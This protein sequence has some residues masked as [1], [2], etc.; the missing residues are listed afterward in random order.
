MCSAFKTTCVLM[1]GICLAGPV[2]ARD[3]DHA[4][5]GGFDLGLVPIPG[6]SFQMMKHAVTFEQWDAC[7]NDGG[8]DHYKPKDLAGRGKKPVININYDDAVY[9]AQWASS[10]TGKSLR[11]PTEAE[12]EYAARGGVHT[13][14]AFG[15]QVDCTQASYGH[16]P[17]GECSASAEGPA[18]VGSYAPNAYGLYDM[19]GNVWQWTSTCYDKNCTQRVLRGGS[20]L[21]GPAALKISFRGGSIPT[22]RLPAYGFRLLADD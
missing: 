6:T 4:L 17:G 5:P 18:V 1:I 15:N 19:S 8:C 12:W 20:W 13:T 16:R 3:P 9:F 2:A 21:D 7:I 11:L 14:Y 22:A 10:K